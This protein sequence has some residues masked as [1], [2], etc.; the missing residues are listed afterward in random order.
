MIQR[1]DVV[2][3]DLPFTEPGRSKV[4]PAV[5]VQND[6]DNQKIQKSIIAMVTGNLR[7]RGDQSHCYVDPDDPE[8]A[9]SVSVSHHWFHVITSSS[10]S[11]ALSCRS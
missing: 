11:K 9:S 7:R 2:I 1:C 5:V 3:V 10:S 6:Q 4:R 8:G